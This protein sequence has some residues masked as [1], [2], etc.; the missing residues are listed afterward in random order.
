M[1]TLKA[2]LGCGVGTGRGAGGRPG[3]GWWPSRAPLRSVYLHNNR[4]SNAG[5]PP[6]AFHGS[7]A[8][9]TLSLSS[10]RLSYLPPSLPPSLERLHLQVPL[11]PLATPRSRLLGGRRGALYLLP[12]PVGRNLFESRPLARVIHRCSLN[13]LAEVSSS[14]LPYERA[15]HSSPLPSLPASF[16]PPFPEQPH[17]QGAPRSPEPPDPPP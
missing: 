2:A 3:A 17:L 14:S 5:L 10:N 1:C 16:S 9:A 13:S 7:E 15:F 12:I 8:V 11:P 4:L 6:D